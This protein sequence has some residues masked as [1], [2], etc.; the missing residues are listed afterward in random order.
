MTR[1]KWIQKT[2]IATLTSLR[3]RYSGSIEYSYLN[4]VKSN[5]RETNG[6]RNIDRK[7]QMNK[8]NYTKIKKGSRSTKLPAFI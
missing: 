2:R 8:L 4:F 1:M 5:Q 7:K 6:R 3:L